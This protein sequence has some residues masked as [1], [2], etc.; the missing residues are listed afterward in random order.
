VSAM[1]NDIDPDF[2]I[3]DAIASGWDGGKARALSALRPYVRHLEH[4]AASEDDDPRVDHC[5]CGLRQVWRIRE[6]AS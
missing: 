4:C 3:A 2:R 1:N 5:D 6:T